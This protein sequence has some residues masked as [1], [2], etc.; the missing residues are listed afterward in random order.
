MQRRFTGFVVVPLTGAALLVSIIVQTIAL[1]V[2]EILA[3]NLE[4]FDAFDNLIVMVSTWG[5]GLAALGALF[6]AD[7]SDHLAWRNVY[8]A[9]TLVGMA[10]VVS[11]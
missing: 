6:Q 9:A 7:D 8:I 1:M 4:T 11:T 10:V 3:G 2:D 5:V